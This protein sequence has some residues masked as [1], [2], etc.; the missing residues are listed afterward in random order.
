MREHDDEPVR[1]LP[2]HLPEGEHIVWQGSP[3][4]RVL[5]RTALHARAVAFY[6][7]A[8]IV[9]APIV[10]GG[11]AGAAATAIAAVLG[12]ALLHLLAWAQ[13]RTT[14]YTLTNRRVVLR[15]GVALQT[16]LNL[17]LGIIGTAGLHLRADGTGDLPLA[18][19]RPGLGYAQLWPHVRP[20]HVSRPEPMLRA[21]PDA[22]RVAA[23]LTDAL[24]SV[25]P[26]VRNGVAAPARTDAPAFAGTVAA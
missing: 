24:A 8:L 21:V 10:G 23:L 1:G 12:L 26:G 2:G 15:F 20:W 25:A 17:P 22:A 16:C 6:F 18:L 13:A 5:A 11:L 19:T 7:A 4:W 9:A 3:D 14:I